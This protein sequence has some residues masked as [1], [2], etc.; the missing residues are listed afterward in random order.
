[1]YSMSSKLGIKP[2]KSHFNSYNIGSSSIVL[3]Y[4]TFTV[5]RQ[6]KVWKGY[7]SRRN[8]KA[9][10]PECLIQS[11]LWHSSP[12]GGKSAGAMPCRQDIFR[13]LVTTYSEDERR[14]VLFTSI[15]GFSCH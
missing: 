5:A 15:S 8:K 10:F 7:N 13:A 12:P 2:R 1:M 6:T 4:C 14:L 11:D 9:T 3:K